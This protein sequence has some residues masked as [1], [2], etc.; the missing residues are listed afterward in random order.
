MVPPEMLY[1]E[2]KRRKAGFRTVAGLD[3][4]G[5][6]PLAGPVVAAA[7]ILPHRKR[8]RFPIVDSKKLTPAR[9]EEVYAYLLKLPGTVIGVGIVDQSE[10]DR[11]NILEATREAMRIAIEKLPEEPACLLIDGLFLPGVTSPQKKLIRGEERSVSIA[12]ASIVAKVTRDRLMI[13][14]DRDYPHYGFARHKGYGTR[15]HLKM[16]DEHGPCPLHRFSF[17]PVKEKSGSIKPA[18]KAAGWTDR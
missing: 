18:L 9:R 12:A 8:F 6:G 2:V 13:S 5:R 16:L 4:A 14:F 17:R 10:I 15:E 11:L 7:V 3:E 1:W